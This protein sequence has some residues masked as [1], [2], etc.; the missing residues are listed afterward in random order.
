MFSK[1]F[2]T[3]PNLLAVLKE[4][5]IVV[6]DAEIDDNDDDFTWSGTILSDISCDVM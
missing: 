5:P 2:L 4:S 6:E 3:Q 1:L